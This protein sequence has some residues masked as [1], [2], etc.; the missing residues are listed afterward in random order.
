MWGELADFRFGGERKS[1]CPEGLQETV[2]VGSA[3]LPVD[4]L[5]FLR[6]LVGEGVAVAHLL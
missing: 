1:P 2:P 3:V 5:G 4:D 6:L